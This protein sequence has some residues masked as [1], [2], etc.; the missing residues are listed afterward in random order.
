MKPGA[1]A[2]SGKET[3]R[4]TTLNAGFGLCGGCVGAP[5]FLNYYHTSKLSAFRHNNWTLSFFS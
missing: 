4:Q 5:Y 3:K 2:A 1:A